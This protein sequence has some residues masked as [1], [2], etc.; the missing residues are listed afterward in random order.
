MTGFAFYSCDDVVDNPAQ[1][2]A[3][4]WNYSV[5]VKFSEFDFTGAPGTFAYQAPKTLY[6]FNEDMTPMGT[7]TTDATPSFTNYVTYAGTLQGAIGNSLIIATKTGDDIAKQDGTIETIIDN[8]IVQ[9]DT[10]L[11][12]I[13]NANS[14]T[15]TTG[16]AKMENQTAIMNV[17]FDSWGGDSIITVSTDNVISGN[18]NEP[19]E[20]TYAFTLSNTIS[21]NSFYVAVP[22]NGQEIDYTI[23]SLTKNGELYGS[24]LE[25]IT[26]TNGKINFKTGTTKFAIDRFRKGY[27]LTL[28]DRYYRKDLGWT[29]Y[30]DF[31]LDTDGNNADVTLLI[32]QSGTAPID[33]S[34]FYFRNPTLTPQNLELIVKDVNIKRGIELWND[35][36]GFNTVKGS[37]QNS[38]FQKNSRFQIYNGPTTLDLTLDNVKFTDNAYFQIPSGITT[39]DITLVGE[40]QMNDLQLYSKVNQKGAGTWTYK[41]LALGGALNYDNDSNP[42][43]VKEANNWTFDKDMTL[44]YLSLVDG[45]TLNIADGVKFAVET[46]SG[47]CINMEKFAT[48]NIGKNAIVNATTKSGSVA[49][50]LE[51]NAKMNIG[52]GAKINAKTGTNGYG[53]QLYEGSEV[54][55]GENAIVNLTPNK[56][57][58]ALY[59]SNS[60]FTVGKN[61][62]VKAIGGAENTL[63]RGIYLY[64]SNSKKKT[65][66]NIEEGA[67]L[68][69]YG[70]DYPAI[71]VYNYVSD[72]D[73]IIIN[74]AKGATLKAIGTGDQY[75]ATTQGNGLKVNRGAIVIKGEG[76]LVATSESH[77]AISVYSN[78]SEPNFSDFIIDGATV[79][80]TGASGKAAIALTNDDYTTGK[81]SF[82]SG[83]LIAT[84]G[85]T[86]CISDNGAEAAKAKIG[87]ADDTKFAD[88]IEGNV[89]TITKK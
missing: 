54:K 30:R 89:R 37:I 19:A 58:Y 47:S 38:N 12:K 8:A 63:G 48:L 87:T 20:K 72:N 56:N 85:G 34:G 24:T 7:I 17:G 83:K 42:I 22:S 29:G 53:M 68:E 18:V 66:V 10:V 74:I 21:P 55:V 31:V 11:I 60:S 80:A 25:D 77:E 3:Q 32:M 35:N 78:Y 62:T 33:S 1:D 2:P 6:V 40:N 64:Y 84:S 81:V 67:T 9:M 59:I 26:L 69:A 88:A 45:A 71:N 52:E 28:R 14:G 43:S 82:K 4:S 27:D 79:E 15:L 50:Y 5:S 75:N 57:G 49:Y 16:S 70:I 44:E 39:A 23:S 51:Y 46:E 36:G 41:K 61:A 13:Y 86:I 65:S 73:S 76:S